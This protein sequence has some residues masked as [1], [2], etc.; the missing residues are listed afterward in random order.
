MQPK[1]FAS[2]WVKPLSLLFVFSGTSSVFESINIWGLQDIAMGQPKLYN[3]EFVVKTSKFSG[4]WLKEAH[5]CWP[6]DGV[7]NKGNA[8]AEDMLGQPLFQISM[9]HFKHLPESGHLCKSKV[10]ENQT[11]NSLFH[12]YMTFSFVMMT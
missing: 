12:F 8:A 2:P 1:G 3:S 10:N 6:S 11:L 4:C 7:L 5:K 9:A